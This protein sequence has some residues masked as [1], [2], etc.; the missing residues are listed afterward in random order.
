VR[1]LFASEQGDHDLLLSWVRPAGGARVDG[2]RVERTRRGH[3]YELIGETNRTGFTVRNPPP[4]EAWFYRVTAFNAR[5]TGNFRMVY[6]YRRPKDGFQIA[7]LKP[8]PAKPGLRVEIFEFE[9][10]A[11]VRADFAVVLPKPVSTRTA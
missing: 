8:V 2:Y 10:A 9:N 4:G 6:L 1:S 3:E 5:G 7:I 11:Q